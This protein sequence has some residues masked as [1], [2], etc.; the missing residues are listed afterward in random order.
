MNGIRSVKIPNSFKHPLF[1][2]NEIIEISTDIVKDLISTPFIFDIEFALGIKGYQPWLDRGVSVGQLI[3]HWEKN[4]SDLKVLFDKRDKTNARPLMVQSIA[5]FIMYL[6]WVNK[7]PVPTLVSWESHVTELFIK[8]VNCAERLLYI[9]SCP[10]HYQSHIQLT[11]LFQELNKQFQKS[12]VI[13]RKSP[14][15]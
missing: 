9:I 7:K 6:F 1:F 3:T 8:P 14:R 5:H 2:R 15:S 4:R 11:Q 12:I 10:D 13:E